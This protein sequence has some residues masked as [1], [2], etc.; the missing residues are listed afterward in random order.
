MTPRFTL[1][2]GL[3]WDYYG[4]VEEKNN[5]FSNFLVTSFDPVGGYRTA[6]AQVGSPGLSS[7]YKPDIQELFAPSQHRLGCDRQRARP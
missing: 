6:L 1:N 7:L 3:R 5:L 4:V 2:Y